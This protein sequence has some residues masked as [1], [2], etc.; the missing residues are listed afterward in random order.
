MDEDALTRALIMAGI[1]MM[2][3]PNVAQGIARGGMFG[4]QG[5]DQALDLRDKRRLAQA[6]FLEE[7]Q[8]AQQRA[9]ALEQAK[10]W[11]AAMKKLAGGVQ[12]PAAAAPALFAG[13]ANAG[14]SATV[15]D[16][17]AQQ[18]SSRM[19]APPTMNADVNREALLR[20]MSYRF[21]AQVKSIFEA[22]RA[23]EGKVYGEPQ[24]DAQGR[25]FVMTD[26]GPHYLDGGFK[27]RDEL[28][29]T[30]IGGKKVFRTKY[31][32]T[33]RGEMGKTLSPAEADAA[34]RGWA[35]F[36]LDKQKFGFEKEKDARGV[37]HEYPTPGGGTGLGY[38]TPSGVTQVPGTGEKERELPATIREKLAE[39]NVMLGKIDRALGVVD[40]HPEAFG[41]KN[42]LPYSDD[43]RQRTNPEGV[44]ARAMVA[45]IGSQKIHDRS[46]AS[47]T[48]NESPRLRPFV[49][50]KSDSPETIKKKLT[51]FRQEYA[52]MQHELAGG[53][54]VS[55]VSIK[56]TKAPNFGGRSP[57]VAEIQAEML[58][59]GIRP[60]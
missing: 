21:P 45:D 1:G 37:V 12:V 46:G 31:D 30:D 38:V 6:K 53:K 15:G 5:Y 19:V 47:V 40:E 36:G 17:Q 50:D 54:S 49:P 3:A 9:L 59:R 7:D 13:G 58:R 28:V 18:A 16:V 32:L 29:E 11:D 55:D 22:Q 35:N 10:A 42:K 26:R 33:S 14:E 43:V 2:G 60:Q 23:G 27:P 51:L 41:L 48:I 56:E 20:E 57:S 39:N 44:D 25:V 4:M 34:A 24:V 8:Q 52:Q